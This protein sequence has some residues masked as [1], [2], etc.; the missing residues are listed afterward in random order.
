MK[1]LQEIAWPV[2]EPTY[3]ADPALSYSNISHYE[4]GGRFNAIPTLFDKLDTPSLVFGS[5]VD[6]LMTGT[7]EE[8]DKLFIV[9]DNPG[10]SDNLK[11]ITM[12][13]YALYEGK[14]AFEQIPDHILAATG[15]EC[16]Y[17]ADDKYLATR[18]KKIKESCKTYYNVL[19]IA[20]DKKVVSQEDIQDARLCVQALKT[21]ERT[22]FY[23]ADN[24]PFNQNVQRFY[25]L[26]FKQTVDGMDYR[27][28]ADL[29]IVNH[30][31][32]LVQP[33]DLKTSSTNEWEFPRAFQQWRYDIQARLYWRL[34]RLTM[35]QDEYFKDFKLLP[36]KFIVVNRRNFKPMVWDFAQTEA[37]GQIEFETP[38]GYK[39]IWRDPY[40]I[41]KEVREYLDK[42]PEIPFDHDRN[43]VHWLQNN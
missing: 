36:F 21:N 13:L 16:G 22:A 8:F 17:Y 9:V 19:C 5:M 3:R 6:T 26:K 11:E 7:Q 14:T 20:K 39:V 28:M 40:V 18:V 10:L 29:I 38:T 34:I 35:D 12:R 23:F 4:K 42:N 25:Q 33:C 1:S 15:K 32:K 43:I 41:A 24:D 37:L 31:K 2:D 27:C 30:E